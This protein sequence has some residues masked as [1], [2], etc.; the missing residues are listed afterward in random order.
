MA[1]RGARQRIQRITSMRESALG[2]PD[3]STKKHLP[4]IKDVTYTPLQTMFED[5]SQRTDRNAKLPPWK[6]DKTNTLAFKSPL[7]KS[8]IVTLGNFLESALGGKENNTALSG[9]GTYTTSSFAYAGGT[10]DRWVI[11]SYGSGR[12]VFRPVV[13]VAAGVAYYGYQLPTATGIASVTNAKDFGAATGACYY[14]DPSAAFLSFTHEIDR[15]SE[16]DAEDC[17]L[18]GSVPTSFICQMAFGDRIHFEHAFKGTIWDPSTGANLDNPA[19]PVSHASPWQTECYILDDF[20]S[21][22]ATP[23]KTTISGYRLNLAPDWL[24]LTGSQGRAGAAEDEV[25]ESPIVEWRRDQSLVEGTIEINTTFIEP[26]LMTGY[27]EGTRYQIGILHYLGYQS[28]T[29]FEG[30]AFCLYLPTAVLAEK[31]QV[32]NQGGCDGYRC[33]FHIVDERDVGTAAG[34][35]SS[36]LICK[37]AVAQFIS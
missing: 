34:E 28:G 17:I 11:V 23:A 26:S 27:T 29:A 5:E 18:Y 15:P 8:S 9:T 7:H 32:V 37:A 33:L 14:E 31:P 3:T 12:R 25:P 30:D 22:G 16:P 1:A 21:P 6:G 4:G 13:R 35:M 24:G 20:D 19:R 10:P 2:T 36:G